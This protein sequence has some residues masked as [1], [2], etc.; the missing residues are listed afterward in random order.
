MIVLGLTGSIGMGKSTAAHMLRRMGLPVHDS[1]ACVH[2]LLGPGGG[3]VRAVA[4]QFPAALRDGAIDRKILGQAVFGDGPALARLEAILHPLVRGEARDF[5]KRQRRHGRRAVL[6]DIPLLFETHGGALCDWVIVVTAPP[7]VQAARVLSR[8]GMT[9][10]RFQQIRARQM[11][12]AEKCRR[13]DF[14]VPSGLGKAYTYGQL[15]AIL[16]KVIDPS[17][18]NPPNRL[19]TAQRRHARNRSRYGN[20]RP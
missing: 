6:L 12:E 5:I 13:A 10:A 14:V 4:A 9:P 11:S 16:R 1:D 8:P 19:L 2:R 7:F 17:G 3:A 18:P 20:N 15:A